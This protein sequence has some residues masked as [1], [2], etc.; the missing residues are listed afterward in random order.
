MQEELSD[1]ELL[2]NKAEACG[3]TTLELYKLKTIEKLASVVSVFVSHILMTLILMAIMIFAS[4]GF[5]IYIGNCLGEVWYGFM[6]VAGMYSVL[7]LIIFLS[8]KSWLYSRLKNLAILQL[9]KEKS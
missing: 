9:L 2:F 5:A 7:L 1:L 8:R 4:I 3:K 6:F